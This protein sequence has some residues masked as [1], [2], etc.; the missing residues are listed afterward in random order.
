MV[1]GQ[2]QFL[3]GSWTASLSSPMVVGHRLHS[4][5]YV[6]SWHLASLKCVTL[7]CKKRESAS[8]KEVT[9]LWD[10]ITEVTCQYLCYNL[11]VRGKSQIL[12]TFKRRDYTRVW[13]SGSGDYSI[14]MMPATICDIFWFHGMN[15]NQVIRSHHPRN[16]TWNA[17]WLFQH[18]PVV[19]NL[20]SS[21]DSSLF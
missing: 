21:Q 17:H 15:N 7:E 10:P 12:S 14:K 18:A 9:I 16:T 1:V 11:L 13:I 2:I 6:G 5:P 8:K 4:V 3:M 19:R 20:D